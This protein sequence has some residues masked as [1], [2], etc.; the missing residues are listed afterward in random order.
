MNLNIYQERALKMNDYEVLMENNKLVNEISR[1]EDCL[2]K[3]GKRYSIF[4]RSRK[5]F[6]KLEKEVLKTLEELK[7][8]TNILVRAFYSKKL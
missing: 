6:K 8:K 3:D 2:T 4:S 5:D 7:N 1:L